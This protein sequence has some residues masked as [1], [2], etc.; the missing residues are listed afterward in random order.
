MDSSSALRVRRL[1]TTLVSALC[2]GGAALAG[3]YLY[4]DLNEFAGSGEGKP[5]AKLVRREAKVR[6]KASTSYVW[7][8]TREEE[9]L[10]RKDS[11][12][13]AEN[14]A[15]SV[16]FDDGTI[17]DLGENSLVVIDDLQK[18][19][20]EAFR[21]SLTVR[22]GAT[23]S[24]LTVG[25]DGK[26]KVEKLAVRMVAPEPFLRSFVPEKQALDVAFKW[27]VQNKAEAQSLVLE[28]GPD[29]TFASSRVIRL[30]APAPGANGEATANVKLE[31][32]TY[33]WRLK[34]KSAVLTETR[35]F[36]LLV[37][38]VPKPLAPARGT[39]VI[40]W[41]DQPKLAF[42]ALLPER[43]AKLDSKD[44]A[45]YEN[46]VELSRDA[47]FKQT[48]ASEAL[49]ANNGTASLPEVPEGEYFWRIRGKFG[50]AQATSESW[51]VSVKR[52]KGVALELVTPSDGGLFALKPQ[53]Q[54]SWRSEGHDLEYRWEV[55]AVGDGG[56][57]KTLAS[58]KTKSQ[59]SVWKSPPV[60]Q[61]RW[62]VVAFAS[63]GQSQVGETPWRTLSIQ[64]ADPIRLV[65]PTRTQGV[66]FWDKPGVF[67]FK[68]KNDQPDAENPTARYHVEV[69]TDATFGKRVFEGKASGLELSSAP[70]ALAAGQ[71]YWR[72]SL[73]K[74]SGEA[75]RMSEVQNFSVQ[76]HALLPAPAHASPAPGKV[77]KP[78]DDKQDVVLSW[79]PV[80][81][82]TSYEFWVD[83]DPEAGRT[84]AAEKG[85]PSKPVY[86]ATTAKTSVALKGI[87]EGKY[88]WHVRAI[89]PKRRPG[90]GSTPTPFEVSFGDLLGAPEVTS[91]EVQ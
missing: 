60:G 77:H 51:P 3:Y 29:R 88:L 11:I 31:G 23:E 5:I 44:R 37:A 4:A 39:Q 10:Y 36:K 6:R 2:W 76:Q 13:T 63:S 66:Q 48:V 70:T 45:L 16:E 18:L 40:L 54:F 79:N 20:G 14:S 84:P 30:E 32:G 21:G 42:R 89:D 1:K 58:Q 62:R 80:E 65:Y 43:Y 81:G 46:V 28:V 59:A 90:E 19:S 85:E 86:H 55:Q 68:W 25:E 8:A 52:G 24:R 41:G 57:T 87:G 7:A 38:A 74:P 49:N 71:Y 17:L 64:D 26:A 75:L 33:F 83:R 15:A 27:Q 35:S 67:S 82:A 9:P 56:S 12:Q 61:Y 34:N 78:Y 91:P 47:S 73:K 22:K 53:L 50:A 69:A 72:V